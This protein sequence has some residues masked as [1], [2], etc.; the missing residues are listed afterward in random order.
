MSLLCIAGCLVWHA[1][2]PP[3][4]CQGLNPLI[5]SQSWGN[6]NVLWADVLGSENGQNFTGNSLSDNYL[7]LGSL[8]VGVHAEWTEYELAEC[9]REGKTVKRNSRAVSPK[10]L[11]LG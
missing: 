1:E 7:E 11:V 2:T 6:H 9:G 8:R 4:R 3:A 5:K 10:L